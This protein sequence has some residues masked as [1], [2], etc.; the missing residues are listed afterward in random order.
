[1]L[2]FAFNF[3]LFLG[4]LIVVALMTV[5][6]AAKFGDWQTP[7]FILV[8][9]TEAQFVI[10]S[11]FEPILAGAALSM[12]PFIVLLVVFF[13]GIPGAF[14]GVLIV[15]LLTTVC[16]QLPGSRWVAS[17]LAGAQPKAE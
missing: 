12:S 5:F 6:A 8:K 11:Y 10:G 16:E 14:L 3:L 4:P 15:I 17:L 7:F 1:M 13:W 2:A 9:V